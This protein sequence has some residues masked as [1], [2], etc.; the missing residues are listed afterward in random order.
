MNLEKKTIK[1][2]ILCVAL[3]V[4]IWG[5]YVVGMKILHRNY[6]IKESSF[7]MIYQIDG[8]KQAEGMLE[9]EGWAFTLNEDAK[10]GRYEVV[11]CDIDNQESYFLK[12]KSQKRPDVNR[13]FSGDYD[14]TNVGFSAT[15]EL[16]QLDLENAVYKI[17][18]LE[19]NGRS[20]YD[21]EIFLSAQGISYVNPTLFTEPD[22]EGAVLKE[23]VEKGKL[24]FYQPLERVFVYQYQENLYWLI[25]NG[26]SYF[27]R[28]PGYM[29]YQLL[30]NQPKKLPL[31]RQQLN[32][33]SDNLG[34]S[35]TDNELEVPDE[36]KYRVAAVALPR[37]YSITRIETGAY[38][39]SAGWLW[40]EYFR[41]YYSLELLNTEQ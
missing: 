28:N 29:Q 39:N 1:H 14:Y 31:K 34:F 17:L 13:Y 6:E 12:T 4:V 32:L 20:A 10:R 21:T 41:P 22:V 24:R 23:V 18:L 27:E 11:L 40:H 19:K 5:G 16:E 2:A 7:S 26:E 8:M 25:E 38:T 36:T 33:N 15:I 30:T 35:F 3:L 9:L 37:E